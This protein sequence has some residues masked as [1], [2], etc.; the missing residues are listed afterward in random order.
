MSSTKNI[1]GSG[2]YFTERHCLRTTWLTI[3][4]PKDVALRVIGQNSKLCLMAIVE[5]YNLLYYYLF[6]FI[7]YFIPSLSFEC[8]LSAR[9]YVTE[10]WPL[11]TSA[12]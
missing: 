5:K 3:T 10:T 11:F 7:N 4:G 12:K 2:D 9:A 1:Y 8:Q 6:Y